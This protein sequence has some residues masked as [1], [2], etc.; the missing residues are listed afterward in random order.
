M[1]RYTLK[2]EN[3]H[4]TES[5]FQ[6][7]AA[8]D[9]LEAGGHLTCSTCCTTQV[10]KSLMAPKV[11]ATPAQPAETQP[12]MHAPDPEMEKAIAE[13]KAKVEKNS[14]YVGDSFVK[15]ARAMHLGD[16]PER[17][18]YGEARL[19]QAKALVEDGVPLM[20]LPFRPSKNLS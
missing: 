18:I 4:L 19:D 10:T 2:C 11:Q 1:I 14:D 7:A 13:L 15:E 17:S 12:M 9:T 3:G 5:W 16:A 8:Y 20:P 6:S